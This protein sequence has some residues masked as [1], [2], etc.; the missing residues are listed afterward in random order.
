MSVWKDL[1]IFASTISATP[2]YNA[3]QGGTYFIYMATYAKQS[4]SISEQ[5]AMLK[6]RGLRFE[7][8]S[9][10]ARRLKNISYFRLASYWKPMEE[11]KVLHIFK[12]GAAFERVLALYDFD[13][14]LRNLL[15]AAIQSI[16]IGLRSRV[17]QMVSFRYGAFWFADETLFTNHA[18]F[19]NCLDNLQR[20]IVRSKEEFLTEHFNKYDNPPYPPAWKALEVSSFGTLAKLY[21]NIA[22]NDLKKQIARDLGLPQHI[23]L[24]SWVKCLSV[25]RNCIA[26]HARIWNR[27]FPWKPQL[28][29]RLR[30]NWIDKPAPCEKL[31]AQLCCIAYLLDMI[32]PGNLFKSGLKSLVAR[33]PVVDTR[34]MGFPDLWQEE[35]LWK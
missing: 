31:Y 5:I 17:I 2:L 10:A 13:K 29:H 19:C 33:Y 24:E 15:F 16:E 35:P 6:Q 7:D 9:E 27:K 12:T 4:I 14:E 26:H 20:E 11:D 3:Y 22:D 25:L 32:L 8:E 30:N 1:L 34:A 23:Y 28:P 18:I 21:C